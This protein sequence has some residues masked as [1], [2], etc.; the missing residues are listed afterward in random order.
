M[1]A[2]GG[3]QTLSTTGANALTL[4]S[5]TNGAVNL[6]NGNNAK[7]INIG[8]G[9]AGNSLNIGTNDTTADTI[10]I[11][12]SKDTLALAASTLTT[13]LTTTS[14]ATTK[15]SATSHPPMFTM[16]AEK[17]SYDEGRSRNSKPSNGGWSTIS[18]AATINP[19][20]NGT[21][22]C[23]LDQKPIWSYKF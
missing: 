11:G 15:A 10:N 13:T 21:Q 2:S 4:D 1:N 18:V 7:T 5:G 20:V 17:K 3:S 9:T 22:K 6:G 16:G 14:A 8:T 12:S 19:R 23:S